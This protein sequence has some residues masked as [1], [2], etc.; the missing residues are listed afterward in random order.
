MS[1]FWILLQLKMMEMVVTTGALRRAKLQS[2]RDNQQ[3]PSFLQAEC[4]FC[5]P[6]NNVKAL[7]GKSITFHKLAYPKLT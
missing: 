5:C 3:T 7:K 4:P 2:N 6:T 1:P